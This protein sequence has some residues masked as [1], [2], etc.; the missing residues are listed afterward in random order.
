MEYTFTTTTK[1]PDDD[2]VF[3]C[4]DWGDESPLIWQGPYHSE[5]TATFTHSWTADNSYDIRVKA[6]DLYGDES[7]WSE[8]LSISIPKIRGRDASRVLQRWY[9]IYPFLDEILRVLLASSV[10]Q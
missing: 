1:E 10:F 4:I 9:Q 6:K 5:N 3:Y 8:S 2:L 7:E